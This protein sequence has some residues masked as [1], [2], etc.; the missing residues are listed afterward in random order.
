MKKRPK[1]N[2]IFSFP[3]ARNSRLIPLRTHRQAVNPP[4]KTT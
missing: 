4:H 2:S 1:I 3:Y